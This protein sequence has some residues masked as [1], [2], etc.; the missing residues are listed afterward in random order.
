MQRVVGWMVVL[1]AVFI[2]FAMVA[3]ALA[4]GAY[5]ASGVTPIPPWNW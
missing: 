1:P 5:M 2:F 3:I 4:A